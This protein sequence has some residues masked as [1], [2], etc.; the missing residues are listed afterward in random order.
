LNNFYY[1]HKLQAELNLQVS[2]GKTIGFVPTMGALHDGHLSLIKA[3]SEH[4]DLT[5]SSIF[6]NPKQF[7]KEEDLV[8]YPRQ[9]D[10][11]CRKLEQFNCDMVYIPSTKDLY[12]E[13]YS[14]VKL[15][16]A[17]LADVYEGE[18]RVGHFDGVVQV[19]YQF[20]DTIKPNAV[21]FG[22]KDYQQ[23][24]VVKKIIDTYFPNITLHTCPTFRDEEG[25]ALSSRNQRLSENGIVSARHLNKALSS[26]LT[27]FDPKAPQNALKQASDYLHNHGLNVEYI[28]FANAD[29][30][31]PFH[32]WKETPAKIVVVAA[33]FVEGVRLID[34]KV[35]EF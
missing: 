33:A 9:E 7:D 28:D 20:F 16:L 34:N 22:Q 27:N 12:D 5:I 8:K 6:V 24:M 15:D 1:K 29:D 13:N 11:D 3:A 32:Q 2:Q 17:H 26:S 18:K 35:R 4:T 10:A 23:C 19:L 31:T 30:L 21:F 14:P 25:L